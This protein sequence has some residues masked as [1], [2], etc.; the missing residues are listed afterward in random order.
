MKFVNGRGCSFG[1]QLRAVR[2]VF[3][4]CTLAW[5]VN[6]LAGQLRESG[7]TRV[8]FAR[9]TTK[10]PS[11]GESNLL[12]IIIHIRSQWGFTLAIHNRWKVAMRSKEVCI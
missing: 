4:V 5:L 11:Q 6:F 10:R 9:A 1:V 7:R 2:R 12:K 8:T 3:A